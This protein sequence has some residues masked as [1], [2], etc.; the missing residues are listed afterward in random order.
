MSIPSGDDQFARLDGRTVVVT[1]ASR[2]I[3]AAIARELAAAGASVILH[4]RARRA[5]VEQVADEVRGHGARAHIVLG[6]LAD[7]ATYDALV[8]QA[9]D[10]TGD[11]HVWVNNAGGDVLTGTAAA[12]SF[13]EKLDYLW[14]VDVLGTIGLSRRVGQRMCASAAAGVDRSIVNVGWDQAPSGMAGDSGEMF[15][16]AKGAVMAFTASLA[17]SLA[18]HVRVNCVAPGW[19]RTAWGAQASEYW[20]LRARHESLLGRWG[21][22]EDVARAIRFLVSPAG[23]FLTGQVL[24]V[25]GGL[26][27]PAGD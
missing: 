13:D 22:P 23:S 20:Q 15:A 1:G 8:A 7:P 2:G 16:A 14:R 11:V 27:G 10:W 26:A 18:P 6:D 24:A 3:G 25:N 17:R 9:W 21:L 19:I 4:A 12:W 5:E